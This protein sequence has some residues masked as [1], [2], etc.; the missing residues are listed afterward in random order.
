M[1]CYLSLINSKESGSVTLINGTWN[2]GVDAGGR[3]HAE[4][5]RRL[6][7]PLLTRQISNRLWSTAYRS[8]PPS[9]RQP[10][11]VDSIESLERAQPQIRCRRRG[12][13]TSP[14]IRFP[15]DPHVGIGPTCRSQV[16]RQRSLRR[17]GIA[18]G[19]GTAPSAR[20]RSALPLGRG[21]RLAS[22]LP[23]RDCTQRCAR[24]LV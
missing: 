10:E 20:T 19:S 22:P 8:S 2:R 9:R 13:A 17:S 16:I 11:G 1:A 15:M 21:A 7:T 4:N 18:A 5:P 3:T 24:F 12:R 6:G 14:G 23:T